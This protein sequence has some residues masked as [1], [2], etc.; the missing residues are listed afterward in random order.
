MIK[1]KITLVGTL[2]AG[3]FLLEIVAGYKTGSIAL[4]ADSFHMLSDLLALCIAFYAIKLAKQRTRKSNLSFGYQRAE[5]LGAFANA[6]FLL[7]LCFTIIIE[8]I[9]RF[10]EPVGEC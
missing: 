4:I 7:A 1:L 3:L 6:V 10:V 2:T 8:A 5:I 9:Q